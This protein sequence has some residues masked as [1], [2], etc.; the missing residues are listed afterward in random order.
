MPSSPQESGAGSRELGSLFSFLS[1]SP[2][3]ARPSGAAL[4]KNIT[5]NVLLLFSFSSHT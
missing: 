3:A 1:L 4:F 2:T 5:R